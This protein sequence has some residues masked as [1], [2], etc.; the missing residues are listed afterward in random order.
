MTF[1]VSRDGVQLHYTV[2]DYTDPWRDRP[3]IILQ[4]GFGRHGGFWYRWIPYLAR[5]Y[6]ILRADMRGFGASREGFSVGAGFALDDLVQDIVAVMDHAGLETAHYVGE[7]FG[8]TLGMQLG[9]QHPDRIR[10]L[11]LLSAPVFLHG[12]VQNNFAIGESSWSDALRKHGVR[13]WAEGT[14]TIS[15]FPPAMGEQFLAWY[16]EELSKTDAETLARFSDL[17]RSYN[18]THFLPGITAPTLAIFPT[19]RSE[20]VELLRQHVP[21]L[22]VMRLE[23]AYFMIYLIATRACAEAVLHFAAQYDGFSPTE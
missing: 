9:S 20:Q 23:T 18:Q 14:N 12:E 2:D 4:H 6:R 1:A 21:S 7:A 22:R 13:K 19:S 15:R 11:S 8:G 3:T 16:S 17:C 5:H 10:T